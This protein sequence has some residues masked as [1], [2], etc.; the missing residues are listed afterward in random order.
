MATFYKP[1][2]EVTDYDRLISLKIDADA[3]CVL[4]NL[5][6]SLGWVDSKSLSRITLLENYTVIN[7][8]YTLARAGFI[9]LHSDPKTH[10]LNACLATRAQ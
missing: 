4:A 5:P 2:G 8:L 3:E 6:H 7:A 1:L 10:L 9:C